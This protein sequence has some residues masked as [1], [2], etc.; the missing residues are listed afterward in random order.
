MLA[1]HMWQDVPQGITKFL[2]ATGQGMVTS[3][4]CCPL[5]TGGA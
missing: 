4:H 2:G 1:R 3:Y 5:Y